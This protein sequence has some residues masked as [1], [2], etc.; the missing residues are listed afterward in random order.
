MTLSVRVEED[1]P[2][3]TR[4]FANRMRLC[5]QR[6]GSLETIRGLTATFALKSTT[7]AQAVTIK[8]EGDQ[9]ALAHG[10]DA[11][12]QIVIHMDFDD[13]KSPESVEGFWR[14]PRLARRIGNLMRL[15]LPNWVDSA[16][17]FWA[18][19]DGQPHMPAGITIVCTNENRSLNFG[20]LEDTVEIIGRSASLE[21]VFAGTSLLLQAVTSGKVRYR[22][23]IRYLAGLSGAGQ[24]VMLGELHG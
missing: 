1:A 17:R 19:T 6:P 7:N 16:K 4:V 23:P 10:V 18:M 24:K 22:G 2:L 9:I 14:H 3:L 21:E 8:I 5:L 12:C 11:D 15:P 20:A 13:P